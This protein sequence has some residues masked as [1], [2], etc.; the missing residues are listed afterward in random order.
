MTE[1]I[2]YFELLTSGKWDDAIR[3]AQEQSRVIED[4]IQAVRT[5]AHKIGHASELA[6][7]M[8]SGGRLNRLG[9]IHR[10]LLQVVECYE[11]MQSVIGQF[12]NMMPELP[13]LQETLSWLPREGRRDALAP[14]RT[15]LAKINARVP[16]AQQVARR[17]Q[18]LC[19]EIDALA[20]PAAQG[21]T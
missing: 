12:L 3:F 8:D 6:I 10:Q 21:K 1:S 15:L 5:L 18:G 17:F 7:A 16:L 13:E 9:G 20:A 11:D 2:N 19:D 14:M 4:E